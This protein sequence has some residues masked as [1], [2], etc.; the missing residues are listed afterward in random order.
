MDYLV[1]S[2]LGALALVPYFLFALA[3]FV[4]GKFIFDWSTPRIEDDRELTERDNPAFGTVFAGYMLGLGFALSGTLASLGASSGANFLNIGVSGLAAILL[5]RASMVLGEILIL[6]KLR[7]DTEI[8]EHRNLGVAF[9][10]AGLFVANG[11]VIM[12]VMMGRSDSPVD[13]LLDIAVYWLMGQAFLIVAWF[14]FRAVAL[15]NAQRAI[16]VDDN[17]AAGLSLAGFFVAV[18]IILLA[19]L[20]GAGSDRV[21]ELLVALGVG[22]VGLV[23]LALAR[24]LASVILLRD[25]RLGAEVNEHKNIAAGA[26]SAL[27]SIVVALLYAA[28]IGARLG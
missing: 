1:S 14:L 7:F 8:V 6:P 13:L 24:V 26:V 22:L 5:L 25:A 15:Y 12:G 2:L 16:A 17:P 11:L 10:F 28:L 27:A 23:L 4:A 3:L 9:A 20:R 18:G 19:A 21:A